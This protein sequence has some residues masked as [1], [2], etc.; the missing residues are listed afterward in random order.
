M[1]RKKKGEEGG[2]TPSP[3][4]T[5]DDDD[6]IANAMYGD[7]EH[8]GEAKNVLFARKRE[9]RNADSDVSTDSD[10]DDDGGKRKKAGAS[11]LSGLGRKKSIRVL[12]QQVHFP[13]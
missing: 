1:L 6:E 8:G 11:P 12:E 13:L 5:L 2:I 3:S 7:E 10:S 4:G 9:A